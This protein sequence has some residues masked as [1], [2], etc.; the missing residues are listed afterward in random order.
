VPT[1]LAPAALGAGWTALVLQAH[2]RSWIA[3]AVTVGALG[4]LWSALDLVAISLVQRE[5]AV[6]VVGVAVYPIWLMPVLAPLAAW[7]TTG[8][9]GG[10]A[11]S[12]HAA[13][14]VAYLLTLVVGFAASTRVLPPG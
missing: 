8:G 9:R 14:G 5:L 10:C 4:L 1:G 13:G 11:V 2:G 7:L 3:V 6:I 12:R